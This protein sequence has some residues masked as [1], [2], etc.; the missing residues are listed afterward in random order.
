VLRAAPEEPKH[1]AQWTDDWH[2]CLH[3]LLTG[4]TEGYYEDY[5]S[6]AALLA[7]CMAE[8]FAYQ[9]EPS[10]HLGGTPRGQVSGHL[11]TTAFIIC[12]QNHDQIG[13]R[14]FGERLSVLASPA[15]LRAATL[16]LLLTPQI[17]MIFMGDEWGET[18]PFLFFTDHEDE[19]ADLVR[20]GRRREFGHFAAFKNPDMRA[21]IPDPNAIGTFTASIPE[22]PIIPTPDQAAMMALY[23]SALR[24][25]RE[26]IIPHLA[27]TVSAGAQPLGTA[28]VR[29]AWKLND[30][31]LL[32]LAANFGKTPLPCEPGG[33][34]VL[35]GE[36]GN[37]ELPAFT[38]CAWL[39]TA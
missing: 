35:A 39:Q 30:G 7:R 24:I 32:T 3:V 13:N 25:R 36:F 8:G 21:K 6:A 12:L 33:G 5:E 38:C 4:E 37:N 1:D 34:D 19:L 10:K 28:G 16:L 2:H 15:A 26:K 27:G 17:P 11:P 23:E 14:A 18:K 31:A 29:A 22:I 20:E 9:G